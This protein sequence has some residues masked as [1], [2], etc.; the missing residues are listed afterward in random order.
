MN[1][2]EHARIA[3]DPALRSQC[4]QAMVRQYYECVTAMYRQFWG[5][6]YHFAIYRGNESRDEAMIATERLIA[7]AGSFRKGLDILEV[8]CGLGGPAL[9]IAEYSG[10]EI[11]AID[12]C[13]HHVRIAAQRA[14]ARGLNDKVRLAVADGMHLPFAD[15]VF[16]RVYVIE[17]GCH[18]PDKAALCRECARVLRSGGEFLG[19]DWMERDD[20]TAW[21][22]ERYI[23]PICRHCSVP[24]MV[25][26][27]IMQGHLANNGFEVLRSDQ[28][29]SIES[30]LPN[31]R[32]PQAALMQPSTDGWDR[33]ALSRI[34]L[35]GQA[36]EK[37]TRAGAFVIGYWHAR[38]LT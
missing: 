6:S 1:D 3:A 4:Y 27:V 26:P 36:L 2:A 12:L 11:T 20:L 10:A 24:N 25:S 23:E 9:Q 31:W 30:L 22:Q 14:S 32:L 18:T 21:E 33:N 5:D 38:R 34:S 7:D 17:A 19:L 8:G 15:A 28:A 16:D 35:G 13:Q 37:A 29:S